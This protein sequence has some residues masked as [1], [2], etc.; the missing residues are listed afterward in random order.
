VEEQEEEKISIPAEDI[1][2]IQKSSQP[3]PPNLHKIDR[4]EFVLGK[5]PKIEHPDILE[6]RI[7]EWIQNEVLLKL[8]ENEMD[9]KEA[10]KS[11]Q[12]QFT[13]KEQKEVVLEFMNDVLTDVIS[14]ET[15][16]AARDAIDFIRKDLQMEA[17]QLALEKTMREKM[18]HEL[19]LKEMEQN[20]EWRERE[21]KEKKRREL[22]RLALKQKEIELE[23]QKKKMEEEKLK[24]EKEKV[25]KEKEEKEKEEKE[26]EK[27]VVSSDSSDF[28][29][30]GESMSTLA[31]E[32]E[33]FTD[34]F[35]F[36]MI[37][38]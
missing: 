8:I 14:L 19:K 3:S 13:L 9:I 12:F 27:F 34:A 23:K 21:K 1:V 37:F 24:R 16:I 11:E 33:V 17:Q 29:G 4:A 20:R 6:R 26:R 30:G 22:E 15:I 5:P 25:E 31:S 28:E 38:L 18:D 10:T 35:R 32:G 7:E 2:S 36:V